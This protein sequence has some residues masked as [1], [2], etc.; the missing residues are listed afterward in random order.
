MQLR[1]DT[2]F[3]TGPHFYPQAFVGQTILPIRLSLSLIVPHFLQAVL[4]PFIR[5]PSRIETTQS[6]RSILSLWSSGSLGFR[7]LFV[8][9]QVCKLPQR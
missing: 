7:N 9:F 1:Q 5:R 4:S 8:F 3:R 6:G 2:D